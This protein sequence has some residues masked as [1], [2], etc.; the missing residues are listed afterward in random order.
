[1]IQ[2]YFLQF[3]TRK[4]RHFRLRKHNWRNCT[5]VHHKPI[6]R[7]QGHRKIRTTPVPKYSYNSFQHKNIHS[8]NILPN[9]PHK[10]ARELIDFVCVSMPVILS[11]YIRIIGIN[12]TFLR[13]SN[14]LHLPTVYKNIIQN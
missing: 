3:R 8:H 12:L 4:C 14:I 2:A 9:Q 11:N 6:E 10:Y 1:M 7:H 13:P 5:H